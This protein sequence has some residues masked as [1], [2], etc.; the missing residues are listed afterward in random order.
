KRKGQVI[1]F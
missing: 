1:Q